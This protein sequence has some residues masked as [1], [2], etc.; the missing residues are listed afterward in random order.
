[1]VDEHGQTI[2]RVH[3]LVYDTGVYAILR[4]DTVTSPTRQIEHAE[5]GVTDV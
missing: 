3:H 2:N 5:R 4:C 1:M